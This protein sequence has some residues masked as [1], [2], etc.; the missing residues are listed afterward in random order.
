MLSAWRLAYQS[1]RARR[2]GP[3]RLLHLHLSISPSLPHWRPPTL[4]LRSARQSIG[5]PADQAPSLVRHA[6]DSA[7]HVVQRRPLSPLAAGHPVPSG[8]Q[9]QSRAAVVRAVQKP[10]VRFAWMLPLP[11]NGRPDST[12]L[13]CNRGHPCDNCTKRTDAA[14]CTYVTP[15]TRKK[16]AT[17][18]GSNNS[19]DEMQ[20]RIDRLEGL[21][22]SLITNGSQSAGPQSAGSAAAA[23]NLSASV[24]DGSVEQAID[25]AAPESIREE[26]GDESEVDQVAKSIGVMKIRNNRAIFASE[27]HWYA[28]LGEV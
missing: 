15:G 28:I 22:L 21:V 18:A 16:S 1:A 17:A 12:R 19:P 9:A 3:A 10:E 5:V 23:M 25:L 26:D 8:A 7:I 20:N 6:A 14:S 13:K 24:S 4:Q 11:G 2:R 27:A